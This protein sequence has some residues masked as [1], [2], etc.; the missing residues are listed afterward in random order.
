M[1][2]LVI[3]KNV[4]MPDNVKIKVFPKQKLKDLLGKMEIGGSTF[5]D[6]NDVSEA[7]IRSIVAVFAKNTNYSKRYTAQKSNDSKGLRIWRFV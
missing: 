2:S 7:H 4:P 3:E 6:F 1:N 5:V